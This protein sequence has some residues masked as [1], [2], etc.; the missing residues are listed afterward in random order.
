MRCPRNASFSDSKC[1]FNCIFRVRARV[2]LWVPQ[3]MRSGQLGLYAAERHKDTFLK[4]NPTTVLSKYFNSAFSKT[5]GKRKSE[6][7]FFQINPLKL[8]DEGVTQKFPTRMSHKTVV[9]QGIPWDCATKASHKFKID[10]II[11]TQHMRLAKVPDK[12]VAQERV[13]RTFQNNIQRHM[14]FENSSP[15]NHNFPFLIQ[16][17]LWLPSFALGRR[18]LDLKRFISFN[19]APNVFHMRLLVC[20]G[21][22]R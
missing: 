5:I 1:S 12:N 10:M 22:K 8:W 9:P 21:S 11:Y 3:W 16:S 2:G 17:N 4:F 20:R 14:Q 19:L 6:Y 18:W 13:S 15:E 7:R